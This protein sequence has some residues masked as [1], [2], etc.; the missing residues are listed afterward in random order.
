M[1]V[2][3]FGSL[4]VTQHLLP[5]LIRTRGS[6]V[7]NIS[8]VAGAHA[9]PGNSAYSA[10][11]FA[12]EAWSDS[13]RVEVVL[14]WW[15]P[16]G[17]ASHARRAVAQLVPLGVHVSK[18]RPGSI[19]T[20]MKD[21]IPAILSQTHR[22]A[23]EEVRRVYGGNAYE[24]NLLK[25]AEAFQRRATPLDDVIDA[26]C[27][28]LTH[29]APKPSYWVGIDAQIVGRLLGVLP[30]EWADAFKRSL[31]TPFAAQSDQS[32]APAATRAG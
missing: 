2:V 31:V 4:L 16:T 30:T 18:V 6:R 24:T 15:W 22:S 11:K 32:E 28:A 23:P 5:L 3:Y 7:I 12:L 14:L 19:D 9:F 17:L 13:L 8:S 29:P 1:E 26:V 21:S 10:A 27:V 20:K 25:G